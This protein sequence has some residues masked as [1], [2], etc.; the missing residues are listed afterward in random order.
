MKPMLP[1]TVE[2]RQL[3]PLAEDVTTCFQQKA[4][5]VRLMIHID[6]KDV[7]VLNRRGERSQNELTTAMRVDLARLPQ[8]NWILDGELIV[9]PALWLFDIPKAGDLLEDGAT[10]YERQCV[11]SALVATWKP[12]SPIFHLPVAWSVLDKTN[13][14]YKVLLDGGEGVV[15]RTKTGKYAPGKRTNDMTK[16]KFY[17][18]VDCVAVELGREGKANIGLSLYSDG[19]LVDVCEVSALVGDGS[20]VS[21]GDVVTIRY[22]YATHDNRIYQPN[23]PRLRNDKRPEECTLDQLQYTDKTNIIKEF[24]NG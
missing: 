21:V 19:E 13:L 7:T 14:A 11:L 23:M 15:I 9:G 22:L 6:G 8:G 16:I 12:K 20:K 17:K 4:D 3:I 5:G 24:T 18:E 2:T 10:F 1:K